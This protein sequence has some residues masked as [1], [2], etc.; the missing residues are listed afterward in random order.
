M[1]ALCKK[2]QIRPST[3]VIRVVLVPR[4]LF[5]PVVAIEAADATSPVGAVACTNGKSFSLCV[6]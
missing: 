2:W 6:Q 4:I 3:I 5:M 1:G